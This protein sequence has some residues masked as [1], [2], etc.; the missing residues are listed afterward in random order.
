MAKID[1]SD[2]VTS[3]NL[4]HKKVHKYAWGSFAVGFLPSLMPG[5]AALDFASMLGVQMVLLKELADGYG[6]PFRKDLGKEALGGVL[7]ALAAAKLGY[8]GVAVTISSFLNPIPVL[9]SILK[10]GIAPGFNYLS[11]IAVG[12]VFEK[13]FAEGGTFLDFDTESM[14]ERVVREY[15]EAKTTFFPARQGA[16]KRLRH[17]NEALKQQIEQLKSELGPEKGPGRKHAPVP[18]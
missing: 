16:V 14:K 10:F 13:H 15:D 3:L 1:E 7:G 9:G 18:A 2:V 11:T 4:S 17:E 8:G 12:R 6:V 5:G